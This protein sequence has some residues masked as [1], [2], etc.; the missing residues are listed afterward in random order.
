MMVRV[1][2]AVGLI[3]E[4]VQAKRLFSW[5]R[6]KKPGPGV[7]MVA[8]GFQV[9]MSITSMAPPLRFGDASTVL[10]FHAKVMPEPRCGMPAMGR[11]AIFWR[12]SRFTT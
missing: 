3:I 5:L 4:S 8:T 11:S 7:G 1:S 2:L 6:M 9:F 12:A 10:P